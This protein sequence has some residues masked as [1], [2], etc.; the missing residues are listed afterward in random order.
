M[1]V[2]IF[3]ASGNRVKRVMWKGPGGS[4]GDL[5]A[6][7]MKGTQ[8]NPC[9]ARGSFERARSPPLGGVLHREGGS[10]A[11]KPSDATV[12]AL[13]TGDRTRERPAF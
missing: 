1:S 12:A 3:L 10:R 5:A 4:W 8:R 9:F 2:P 11:E 7:H 13:E 6:L